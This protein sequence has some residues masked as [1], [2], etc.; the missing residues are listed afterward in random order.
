MGKG[1]T[2]NN[3]TYETSKRIKLKQKK[4]RS[5]YL[6]GRKE[7]PEAYFGYETLDITFNFDF[8]QKLLN[9]AKVNIK[10]F[11]KFYKGNPDK[12]IKTNFDDPVILNLSKLLQVTSHE[13]FHLYQCITSDILYSYIESSLSLY[14]M[15]TEFL[16]R[17]LNSNIKYKRNQTIFDIDIINSLKASRLDE[18]IEYIEGLEDETYGYLSVKS[19]ELSLI[20]IIEGSAFNFQLMATKDVHCETYPNLSEID[21]YNKAYKFFLKKSGI[22]VFTTEGIGISRIVFILVSHF[23][24][25]C[26]DI[27]SQRSIS[28]FISL[29]KKSKI[30][31]DRLINIQVDEGFSYNSIG[32]LVINKLGLSTAVKPSPNY[33]YIDKFQDNEKK[34]LFN[35]LKNWDKKKKHEMAI[36]SEVCNIVDDII[37]KITSIDYYFLEE[38]IIKNEKIKAVNKYIKNQFPTFSTYYFIPYLLTD[39][40]SLSKFSSMNPDIQSIK[41]KTQKIEKSVEL[42]SYLVNMVQKFENVL[43]GESIKCCEQ[44]G[45]TTNLTKIINCTNDFSFNDLFNKTFGKKLS[46]IIEV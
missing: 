36:Y 1:C 24:L 2:V 44:H 43:E 42:D 34:E 32:S 46:D 28:M 27:D 3:K 33:K 26:A 14:A 30:F 18:A 39:F 12:I 22:K 15:K 16:F 7:D 13:M 37:T 6:D 11:K 21:L 25:L 38:P 8:I 45:N 19:N 5:L 4:M 23:S 31:F 35:I 29:S 10:E 41:Y 20:N 9:E 40:L 17:V